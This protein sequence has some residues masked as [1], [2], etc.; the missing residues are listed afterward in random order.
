MTFRHTPIVILGLLLTLAAAGCGTAHQPAS[1]PKAAGP[2]RG[3]HMNVSATN[4]EKLTQQVPALAAAGVNVL[5]VQVDYNFEFQSHPELRTR[6]AITRP[7]AHGLAEACRHQNIRLIPQLNCLGHQSGGSHTGALLKQY[8]Q[9]DETPGK[10]PGNKGIYCRSWCPLHPEVNKIVF[11]LMDELIDAFEADALHVG[12]DEVMLIGSEYCPRCKGKNTAELFAQAVND[13]HTHLVKEKKVEMLMWGDRLLDS[14]T[15]G[16]SEWDAAAN[17]T[18]A[19][20]DRIPK[21]III[22]DWHYEKRDSYPSIPIFLNKGFRVWP[23][24]W[25]KVPATQ[26]FVSFA[27][28]QKNPR[29]FGYL[30]T[31]WGRENIDHLADFPSLRPGFDQLK[32]KQ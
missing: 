20:I 5:V 32:N 27:Q 17:G 30:C 14:K 11:A 3:F 24:G 2:W 6:R 16:Y 22:C 4:I 1:A 31:T 9:F 7:Q 23:S 18:A 19:A 28:R 15:T 25:Y 8:P 12:M 29:M 10:F 21:D 26:A 13:Y